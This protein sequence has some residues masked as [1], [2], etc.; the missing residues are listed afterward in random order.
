MAPVFFILIAAAG[1]MSVSD[2]PHPASV[3][4]GVGSGGTL[5]A[6]PSGA[7][8]YTNDG[9]A[10]GQYCIG[11]CLKAWPPLTAATSDKPIG[12][13]KPHT[14]PDGP[15]QWF[16][17]D[18]PVYTYA[19]DS[20][21]NE[22]AGD[23]MGSVWHAMHFVGPTPRVPVPPAAK[24]AKIGASF[25]L[26]DHLGFTLYSFSLDRKAPACTAACIE[27]WPP[28]LAPAL[29]HP[30]GQWVPVDRPDG[31]R[32]WAYRGRLM[33]TFSDDTDPGDTR[34]ADAGGVWKTIEVNS[35]DAVAASPAPPIASK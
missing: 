2:D 7:A 27:V 1:A 13:W 25:I 18:A 15:R 33:Y 5:L 3:T 20:K 28:L 17:K 16:Y 31:L 6:G 23:G 9:D 29:A 12:D 26:T 11:E 35:Q 10:I 21:P 30:V 22:A 19:G 14:R 32:Q 4:V 34:G 8:L 24:V